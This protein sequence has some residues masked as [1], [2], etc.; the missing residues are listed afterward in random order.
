MIKAE[1]ALK[2]LSPK[3]RLNYWP[4]RGQLPFHNDR[5]DVKYRALFGGGGSGK[6]KAGVF[7]CLSWALNNPGMNGAY[8]EPSYPMVNRNL[9]PML[10][11]FLGTPIGMSPL[12]A[13]FNRKEM[14]I[15][16][17]NDSKLWLGSLE[18]EEGVEGQ[19]L[20]FWGVDEARKVKNLETQ[21]QVLVRRL[22][23]WKQHD[24]LGGWV[25]TTP[26]EPGSFLF[27]FFEDPKTKDPEAKVYRTSIFDNR[28]NLPKSYIDA[29]LRTHSGGLAERFI[30]GKFAHIAAGSMDF[31]YTKHVLE[32]DKLPKWRGTMVYGVDYGWTNPSAIIA[33]MFD[34]DGRGYVV[35]EFY[36]S[37]VRMNDL[38]LTAKAM[39]DKWGEGAFYCDPS[40]PGAIEDMNRAGIDARG[41]T[42][43][44]EDGVRELGSRLKAAEDGR[45]RLYVSASCVNL[46]SELQTYD[47]TVKANDHAVDALR[48][49]LASRRGN[50][51]PA[52]F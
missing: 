48:Y 20:D 51:P 40:E 43:K 23:G 28:E 36:Q 27:R 25:T 21:F 16:F 13:S 34:G 52:Y 38:I 18:V 47:E 24:R 33:V 31:D 22:R 44:R 46:I 8:F 37:R 41:N 30:W 35:D 2:A 26:D 45:F 32:T 4:H 7:E 49:A 15:T 50:P 42:T 9:I 29:M 6:T 14:C 5:Y 12:V 10:E 17:I 11:F 1:E 3:V 19:N 39:R